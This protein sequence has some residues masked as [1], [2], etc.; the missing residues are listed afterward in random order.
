MKRG[1]ADATGAA[2]TIDRM[3]TT[4]PPIWTYK[5]LLASGRS[6]GGIERA[7]R[8]GE[9]VS[10][11]RGVYAGA[12]ACGPARAAATHGG[13]L[14]CVT[15][16]RHLGL[17]VLDGVEDVHVWLGGHGHA[18]H[19]DACGCVEHWD[20]GAA[21]D[22]FTVPAVPRIL[23]QILTCKGIVGF[24]VAL[25][26]AL[27]KGLITKA[28]LAWLRTHTNGAAREA[29]AYARADADSGLESLFRWRL[30]ELDVRI[31]SQVTIVGVG[32]VDFLI[33]DRLIVEIDGRKNHEGDGERH[34]DLVRDA[35]AAAWDY[36]TLRFDYAQVVHDWE[37]VE[38]AIVA[39]VTAKH[40]LR[41]TR[42][43]A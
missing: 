1:G 38:A 42:A 25:E 14:A 16:A 40:H 6:R 5:Q 13:A 37:S 33:G 35:A 7:A 8:S 41:R 39:Q 28:G 22:A 18:Y 30:R 11:R 19:D 21:R 10:L 27:R 43:L 2:S 12:D 34:K 20:D 26:S 36:V 32:R 31:R 29:V 4:N 9:L 24:F 17:W 23:R 3:C 15:A